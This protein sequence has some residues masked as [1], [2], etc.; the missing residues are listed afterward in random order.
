M[1]LCFLLQKYFPSKNWSNKTIKYSGKK[2][3]WV[4]KA[5]VSLDLSDLRVWSEHFK[6]TVLGGKDASVKWY[7]CAFL[8]DFVS[9]YLFPLSSADDENVCTSKATRLFTTV[10]EVIIVLS[11]SCKLAVPVYCC[12]LERTVH[13]MCFRGQIRSTEQLCLVFS[14]SSPPTGIKID[15]K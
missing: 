6:G 8:T 3:K 13:L 10:F 9:L 4:G 12:Y 7:G 11:L 15:S 1:N 14:A 5:K 2:K